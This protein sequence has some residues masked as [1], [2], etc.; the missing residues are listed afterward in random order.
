MTRIKVCG[1]TNVE[2]ARQA[3]YLGVDALGLVFFAASSRYVSVARAKEISQALPPFVSTVGL[4]VNASIEQVRQVCAEVP[5]HLL[6]FHGDE[7]P[8]YCR[9]FGLPYLK[10]VRVQKHT[11]ILALCHTYYDACGLLCD[12][13]VEGKVGGTGQTFDWQCLPEQLPLPLVLSGGLHAKNVAEAIRLTRPW[14]VDVSSGV[15]SAPG[16]KESQ[17]IAEFIAATQL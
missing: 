6:Q 7:S 17:K 3:A 14:A 16:Q 12:A 15:E 2:Q 13:W 10:A 1:F 9:Q 8:A 4:F 11:D 5:L